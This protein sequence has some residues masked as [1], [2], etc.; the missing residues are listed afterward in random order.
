MN[1]KSLCALTLSAVA[2]LGAAKRPMHAPDA[3][4]V[5]V[6]IIAMPA[7]LTALRADP[8]MR[9][10]PVTC[11]GKS[12]EEQVMRF[13]LPAGTDRATLARLF[14]DP[15]YRRG[16]TQR[17]WFAG[18]DIPKHCDLSVL[19]LVL[20]P[21]HDPG[22][23]RVDP[24]LL[25]AGPAERIAPLA[26]IAHDCGFTRAATRPFREGDV[27]PRPADWRA[28]W[29]T[30]DAGAK[31]APH[32]GPLGCFHRLS[33]NRG[34]PLTPPPP[35]NPPVIASHAA[36]LFAQEPSMCIIQRSYGDGPDRREL[37]LREHV[38]LR[39][40]DMVLSR[41]QLASEPAN[42]RGYGKATLLPSGR[43]F[44]GE[45]IGIAIEDG[46]QAIRLATDAALLDLLEA[47]N[48]VV[49]DTGQGPTTT[50]AIDHIAV[51][52]DTLRACR[53]DVMRGWGVD[54]ARFRRLTL[55][56]EPDPDALARYF[57]S[58]A[59]PHDALSSH[60]DGRVTALVAIAA[61]GHVTKCD[62]VDTSHS[63]SLDRATCE[64]ALK[65]FRLSPYRDASG[66]VVAS[67][68]MFAVRWV[69]P[70]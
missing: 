49:L 31:V 59:Y 70:H 62:V 13:A 33:A 63:P 53:D 26:G 50:L 54:P 10:W 68:R 24:Q 1:R 61:D 12:G 18:D 55:P 15:H 8:A 32:N 60:H 6:E 38:G 35:A 22:G 36:W 23:V 42:W 52:R 67:W 19:N 56:G 57:P 29:V 34:Q 21:R 51:P 41:P 43:V 69:A 47:S 40:I 46:R 2:L 11:Q 7:E 28:D 48:A 3:A 64:I 4:P 65:R 66:N 44:D 30:L 9:E 17:Y 27:A 20:K 37:A 5:A 14:N 58:R 39:A 25:T 45:T 16:S